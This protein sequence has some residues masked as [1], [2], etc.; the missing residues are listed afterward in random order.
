M[1][2]ALH[3]LSHLLK[4]STV[5]FAIFIFQVEKLISVKKINLPIIT[6]KVCDLSRTFW[7]L[8]DLNLPGKFLL[9]H[10]GFERQNLMWMW[11]NMFRDRLYFTQSSTLWIFSFILVLFISF[12]SF[13][14]LRNKECPINL[15]RF[16]T[17]TH[18]FK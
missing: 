1:R 12:C 3:M 15:T 5:S 8:L 13:I 9:Y 10:I 16:F 17:D 4:N 14:P 11:L 6:K 2:A 18:F 7:G